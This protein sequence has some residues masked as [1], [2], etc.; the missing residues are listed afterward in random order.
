MQQ[1]CC[2][3]SNLKPFAAAKATPWHRS[4]ILEQGCQSLIHLEIEAAQVLHDFVSAD[5]CCCS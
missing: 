2:M 5:I 3:S 4:E 1:Y